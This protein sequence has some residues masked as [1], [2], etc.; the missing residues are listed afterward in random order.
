M[1]VWKNDQEAIDQLHKGLDD[2][3]S[4]LQC[5]PL[6]VHSSKNNSIWSATS[7]KI[8][9]ISNSKFYK[10]REV[11]NASWPKARAIKRPQASRGVLQKRLNETLGGQVQRLARK[12]TRRKSTKTLKKR[13]PPVRKEREKQCAAKVLSQEEDSAAFR[14]VTRSKA[15][16]VRAEEGT[17][18]ES[19]SIGST[20]LEADSG[21][22]EENERESSDSGQ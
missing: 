20:D 3:F 15:R 11:G 9:F 6:A 14:R 13:K 18:L 2:L 4:Q 21:S 8:N 5:L 10:I 16:L 19:S 22:E 1:V 7:G 12:R 17:D